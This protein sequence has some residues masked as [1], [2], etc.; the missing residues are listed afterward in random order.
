MGYIDAGLVT[1][2]LND[3]TQAAA[4]VTKLQ[5]ALDQGGDV[6]FI[7]RG[8]A[9]INAP[10]VIGS[11]TNLIIDE[12][13][14]LTNALDAP[15]NML[16]SSQFAA[17]S[18]NGNAAYSSVSLD[19]TAGNSV[20]VTWEA[21]GLNHG[22]SFVVGGADQSYYGGVFQVDSVV[23][24]NNFTYTPIM[25]P[26]AAPTGTV[27]AMKANRNIRVRGGQFNYNNP[28]VGGPGT[29]SFAI[30]MAFV[31]GLLLE[32]LQVSN[33]AK[34]CIALGAVR[35]AVVRRL[36]A[37]ITAS[38]GI[39]CYGPANNVL[40][41]GTS[42]V[43]G[44]DVCSFHNIEN[45]GGFTQYNFTLGG[46]IIGCR[47]QNLDGKSPTSIAVMYVVTSGGKMIDV[48]F[49]GVHGYAGNTVLR[50]DGDS[51]PCSGLYFKNVDALGGYMLNVQNT[52]IDVLTLENIALNIGTDNTGPALAILPDATIGTLAIKSPCT[53]LDGMPPQSSNTYLA[54]NGTVTNV[55]FD[56]ACFEGD[57]NWLA[58]ITVNSGSTVGQVNING[59]VYTAPFYAVQLQ[60][61]ALGAPQVSVS[62]ALLN[63]AG[64]LDS[65]IS[66]SLSVRDCNIVVAYNGILR[67]EGTD[68]TTQLSMSGNQIGDVA[69][70]WVDTGTGTTVIPKGFDVPIDIGAVPRTA[71][72]YCTANADQGTIVAGNLVVCDASNAAGSWHQLS[73]PS[74]VY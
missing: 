22:D 38:D 12:G 44:D 39:K 69:P 33:A 27:L 11:N 8:I 4:N 52:K 3:T 7:G 19:W 45:D 50:I 2:A 64:V 42:G 17:W 1:P 70:T 5:A 46:D 24:A 21:H 65:F 35:D 37:P 53:L 14:I 16:V 31:Q 63:L 74:L 68:T 67:T 41:D 61:G 58:A 15:G 20:Q 59:G 34:Y 6:Y 49:D 30:A 66:G 57:A 32:D 72:A 36:H 10:L 51:G 48:G 13:L 29:Q 28:S 71:G 25:Q 18:A 54:I 9:Y 23:D 55:T 26:L 43:F 47:G 60:N 73:D 40:V 62:G 56:D